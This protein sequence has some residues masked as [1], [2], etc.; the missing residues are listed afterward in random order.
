MDRTA[1]KKAI[2]KLEYYENGLNRVC[3]DVKVTNLKVRKTKPIT[4]DIMLIFGEGRRAEIRRGVEYVAD[5]L[6]RGTC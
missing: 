1:I 5:F 2:E 6:G 4:A 3:G